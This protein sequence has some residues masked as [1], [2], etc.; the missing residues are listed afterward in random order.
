MTVNITPFMEE[1]AQIAWGLSDE[2]KPITVEAILDILDAD[3]NFDKKK[4]PDHVQHGLQ[5]SQG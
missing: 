5:R 3:K 2:E 1:V 4:I